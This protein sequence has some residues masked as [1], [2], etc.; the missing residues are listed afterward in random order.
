MNEQVDWGEVNRAVARAL[1]VKLFLGELAEPDV[2]VAMDVVHF[3]ATDPEGFRFRSE[4]QRMLAIKIATKRKNET[5][6]RLAQFED[7][8]HDEEGGGRMSWD[9]RLEGAGHVDRIQE[10]GTQTVGGTTE[11]DLNITYNYSDVYKLVLPS[12]SLKEV[13]E[14]KT[15]AETVV[16]L[17]RAVGRLG[18]QQ[19]RDYW[20]PT[21][22]NAGFALNILI[23]WARQYPDGVWRVT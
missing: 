21:P 13:L 5:Y 22:G 3:W 14:G 23:G 16:M 20:A 17:E 12:G 11:A 1:S 18:T 10:G 19:F 9:V 8:S 4:A 6:G 2:D 15:G 7:Q